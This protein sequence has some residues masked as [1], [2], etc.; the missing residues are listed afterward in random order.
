MPGA[1]WTTKEKRLLKKQ[2][3]QE[4]RSLEEVRLA[5]RSE[6]AVRRQAARMKLVTQR[7]GRFKWPEPQIRKLKQLAREG[8][9]A[10]EICRF[11]LLGE[12][13]R[14]LWAVRKMWGRLKLADRRRSRQMQ[15]RKIWRPG[16]RGRFDRYL[17]QHSAHMTPEE[18]GKVWG[19]ARSTVARRQTELGVK[20]T[21]QEVL[22]MRYSRQK[23]ER[24]RRRLRRR[25]LR[26]WR[27]RRQ[28]RERQL[29]A[30]AAEYRKR[31]PDNQQTCVDC[32]RTWP[33]RPEFFHTSEKQISIGTSRYYKHRCVLC[34]NTRRRKREQSRKRQ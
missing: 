9:S 12:P 4:G 24:A 29:E 13:E 31:Q 1:R 25:N 32:D 2:I 33:R 14:S 8:L 20:Q 27:Q 15:R 5:G 3:C 18:I 11:E 28:E 6:H 30:L 34:E 23:R 22:Q 17:Q 26:Y 19:V 16:E 10:A 21:R 7:P